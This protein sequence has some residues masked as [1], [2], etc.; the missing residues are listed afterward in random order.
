M[1]SLCRLLLVLVCFFI[2]PFSARSQTP[3]PKGPF[4]SRVPQN[5]RWEIHY[6]YGNEPKRTE[7]LDAPKGE[8]SNDLRPRR[9]VVIKTPEA[10]YE[11]TLALSG[12]TWRRWHFGKLQLELLQIGP[13]GQAFALSANDTKNILV[14]SFQNNDFRDLAWLNASNFRELRKFGGVDCLFFADDVEQETL[15]GPDGSK[16]TKGPKIQTAAWIDAQSRLPVKF[17]RGTETRIYHY[18]PATPIPALPAEAKRLYD[19]NT[20]PPPVAR[21]VR[22]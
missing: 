10:L 2:A 15:P 20:T 13:K 19:L 18:G 14:S 17:Q 8:V 6:Q 12:E 22:P 5:T 1:N 7:E 9:V 4:V 16:E 3:A 21:I 11:Q